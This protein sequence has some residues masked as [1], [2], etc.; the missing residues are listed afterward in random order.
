MAKV[1][2]FDGL[3][4]SIQEALIDLGKLVPLGAVIFSERCHPKACLESL[5]KW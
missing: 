4:N 1:N 3:I 2:R 5:A